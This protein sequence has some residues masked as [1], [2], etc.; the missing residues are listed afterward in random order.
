MKEN[1]SFMWNDYYYEVGCFKM[2]KTYVG[3]AIVYVECEEGSAVPP[4]LKNP[5]DV[6]HDVS[7]SSFTLSLEAGSPSPS[8]K[9]SSEP[10]S[11][12]ASSNSSKKDIKSRTNSQKESN[13]PT[14]NGDRL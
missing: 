5:Q 9:R 6:T 4:F 13:T 11:P 3:K 12:G 8:P 2:P 7:Y 1:Y 14:V 10:T